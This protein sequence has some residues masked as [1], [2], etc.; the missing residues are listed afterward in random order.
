MTAF[1]RIAVIDNFTDAPTFDIL[2]RSALRN[3]YAERV[4]IPGHKRGATISYGNIRNAYPEIAR[5]YRSTALARRISRIVGDNIQRTPEHD[6]SS[7]SILVYSNPGDRIGWHF[8][9]NFY[10]GRHFTALLPLVNESNRNEELS[11]ARLMVNLDGREVEIPTPPNRLI[12]FEGA[13]VR[14]CVTPQ[15]ENE[16]RTMLSM[17]FCTDPGTTL[18]K[19]VQRRFKDV[20]Y[21]GLR[22]LWT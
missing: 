12:I 9:H 20:A 16:S 4:T 8:D 3:R 19:D 18:L 21:I 13:R 10:N 15:G 7:C 6:Q 2:K 17:T 5:F 22:A 14:H 11:S 1:D